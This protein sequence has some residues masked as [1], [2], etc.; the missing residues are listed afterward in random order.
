M[1]LVK[2]TVD[3]TNETASVE[4]FDDHND[5]TAQPEGSVITFTSSD[6]AAATVTQRADDAKVADI[7]ILAVGTT[8][9]GAS[10][11]DADGNP[12][13]EPDGSAWAPIESTTVEVDPGA[14]VGAR[15][16]VAGTAV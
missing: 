2:V 1:T 11:A 6:E 7:G 16:S 10:V 15:M 4:F 12:M 9:I 14:A 3:T 13:T 5:V 8:D